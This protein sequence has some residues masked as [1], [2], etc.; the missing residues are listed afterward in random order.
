MYSGGAG[1]FQENTIQKKN[2]QFISKPFFVP[3]SIFYPPVASNCCQAKNFIWNLVR[4][5]HRLCWIHNWKQTNLNTSSGNLP[6]KGGPP[7]TTMNPFAET[8]NQNSDLPIQFLRAKPKHLKRQLTPPKIPP[9]FHQGNSQKFS[10]AP[11]NHSARAGLKIQAFGSRE[12]KQ[13]RF[14]FFQIIFPCKKVETVPI[15]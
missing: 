5:H 4:T 15:P 11:S 12:G 9:N 7:K 13:K 2:K 14:I 1:K 8:K 6:Q 10:F 3:P